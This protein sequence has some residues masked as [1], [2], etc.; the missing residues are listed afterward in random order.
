MGP[1]LVPAWP[2]V[3]RAGLPVRV[4][5]GAGDGD[6]GPVRVL[7]SLEESPTEGE[8]WCNVAS[9]RNTPSVDDYPLAEL[10]LDLRDPATRDAVVRAIWRKLRPTEPE[11]LTAPAFDFSTFV[12]GPRVKLYGHRL[13][14]PVVI[15][16]RRAVDRDH[17]ALCPALADVDLTST[18]VDLLALACCAAAVLA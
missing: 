2:A 4:K 17:D 11:P 16:W 18:D 7:C 10:R 9:T 1:V 13:R 8:T 14:E 15:R 5:W 12:R 6:I 3:L